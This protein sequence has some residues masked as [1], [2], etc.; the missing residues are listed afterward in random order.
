[1][2]IHAEY[3]AA[4]VRIVASEW[5]REGRFYWYNGFGDKAYRSEGIDTKLLGL[6]IGPVWPL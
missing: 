1:M 6:D 4:Q 3:W 2:V 5:D